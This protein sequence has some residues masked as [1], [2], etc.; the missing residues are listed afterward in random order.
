VVTNAHDPG[1]RTRHEFDPAQR[2]HGPIVADLGP[3]TQRF[4]AVSLSS[5]MPFPLQ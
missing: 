4:R 3:I 2:S 1:Y 5:F